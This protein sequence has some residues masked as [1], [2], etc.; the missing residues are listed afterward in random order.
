MLTNAVGIALYENLPRYKDYS[1][2]VEK[3]GYQPESGVLTIEGD[4]TV[5]VSLQI[6]NSNISANSASIHIYPNP[7]KSVL[8]IESEMAIQRIELLTL[9]GSLSESF[10]IGDHSAI[11]NLSE[12]EKGMYLIKIYPEKGSPMMKRIILLK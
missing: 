3:Q 6:L 10:Y 9:L 4:T 8:H 11:L 1:Y 5:N 2:S 7:A 12:L